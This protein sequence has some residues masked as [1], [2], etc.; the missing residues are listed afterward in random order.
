MSELIVPRRFCG[1]PDSGNGGWTAGALA[2]LDPADAPED[3]CRSW[4]AI[5]V[6]LRRPP[7]LDTALPVTITDGV[8]TAS[9]DGGP[10]ATAQRVDR[11]LAEVEPVDPATAEAA[12]AAY[13]GHDFHPFPTCF[14][15]GTAREE[16]DGL[17]IFPGKV[18]AGPDGDL[19][20]SSWT[21][22]PSLRE[23]WHTYVDEHPRASVAATWAALDCIGGWAGDLTE[24]LMVLGRMTA[25]VDALPVVGE[26]H[27]VV[28][29][30]RGQDGRKTFTASTL[31]DSDGRVVATAEH[32]WI[33]VD[34]AMFGGRTPGDHDRPGPTAL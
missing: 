11:P 4:P 21:P 15:C 10:V 1:P 13:P 27:V 31:Y 16:G 5:E 3:H 29:E 18:G 17:R 6:S 30:G 25:R 32:T 23:D 19:V 26:P 22:H 28:G 33:A 34:P 9:Y 7:P 2:A 8:T 24:R 14:A 12:R 20:A